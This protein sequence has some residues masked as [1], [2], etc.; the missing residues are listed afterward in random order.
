MSRYVVSLLVIVFRLQQQSGLR[1]DWLG[2]RLMLQNSGSIGAPSHF[3]VYEKRECG[4]KRR[5]NLCLQ[6]EIGE[7]L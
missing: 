2:T 6:I 4:L 5:R 1:I 3:M 7:S